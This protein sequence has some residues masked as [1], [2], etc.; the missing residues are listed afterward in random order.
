MKKKLISFK[1]IF[2]VTILYFLILAGLVIYSLVFNVKFYGGIGWFRL[3][4]HWFWFLTSYYY[5]IPFLCALISSL[6]FRP[7]WSY[8]WKTVLAIFLVHVLYS[9]IICSLRMNFLNAWNKNIEQSKKV[10]LKIHSFRHQMIDDDEDQLIDGIR[11]LSDIEASSFPQGKYVV[12]IQLIQQGKIISGGVIG[13]YTFKILKEKSYSDQMVVEF[14]TENY[15]D[16]LEKG[17]IDIRL[18]LKKHLKINEYGKKII[19]LSRWAAFFRRATSW[20]GY[21]SQIYNDI[22]DIHRNDYVHSFSLESEKIQR[23]QVIFQKYI[24]DY[25]QD[26]DG[27]GIFDEMVVVM[28]VDS[29]YNGP[30]YFQA[31]LEGSSVWF[32][33]KTLIKKGLER[34]TIVLDGAKFKKSGLD[35]PY[36]IRNLVLLNNDPYCPG[37]RCVTENKPAFTVYLDDYITNAYKAEN[38]E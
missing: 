29:I 36:K 7:F 15:K 18:E 9:T 16:F 2:V 22:I 6:L 3:P 30:I 26:L 4:T 32:G 1:G 34:L 12:S 31:D 24:E 23:K 21:D 37:G 5:I 38:F 10:Q 13:N 8:F 20:E 11:F 17:K 14:K 19:A 28:E 27:D 33:N 25:G 35:G